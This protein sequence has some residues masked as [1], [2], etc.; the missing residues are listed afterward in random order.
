MKLIADSGSTKA[1][2]KLIGN[3]GEVKDIVDALA[4]V[5]ANWEANSP[6]TYKIMLDYNIIINS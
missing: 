6:G 5:Q 1:A 2:W 4:P 3:S